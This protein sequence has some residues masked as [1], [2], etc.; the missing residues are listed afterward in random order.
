LGRA[1]RG[2]SARL[3]SLASLA[4]SLALTL[5]SRSRRYARLDFSLNDS[6]EFAY[7]RVCRPLAVR[8]VS[9]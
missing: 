3:F 6:Q 9:Q 8:A 5:A 1:R 4:R 2:L 7:E